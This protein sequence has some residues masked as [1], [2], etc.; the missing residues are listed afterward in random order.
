MRK[1]GITM[2]AG[3]SALGVLAVGASAA[4]AGAYMDRTRLVTLSQVKQADPG[5]KWITQV[6][7]GTLPSAYCGPAS[8]EGKAVAQRLAR[9]YTDEMTNYGTQYLSRYQTEAAAKAAYTS[10]LATLKTCK[11]SKPAPTHARRITE[12]RHI[13]AGDATTILRW[14]DYALPSDP[15]SEN[16]AFPYAVTRKGTA[17]SV[18]AFSGDGVGMKAANFDKIAKAAAAKLP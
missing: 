4:Q 1:L 13:V 3:L 5:T 6:D 12:N 18:L 9:G 15:G 17:V 2:A 16:G 8:T 10:I 14:W 7:K 11:Y